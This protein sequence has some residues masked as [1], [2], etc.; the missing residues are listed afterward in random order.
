M[1]EIN[2]TSVW[3]LLILFV[4][5]FTLPNDLAAQ[6]TKGKK[7]G[8]DP[9]PSEEKKNELIEDFAKKSIRHPGLFE[10]YQDSVTGDAYMV[11]RDDQIGKEFIYFSHTIDGIMDVRLIRGGYRG[12]RIVTINKYFERIQIRVHNTGFYYDPDSQLS[13][14]SKA[15]VNDPLVFSE[16]IKAYN[17]ESNQ[18]LI[19]A[20]KLF[21]TEA[22]QQ[23]KPSPPRKPKPAQFSLGSLSKDKSRYLSIRNYP[24]NSDVLVDYVFETQYPKNSGSTA[25]KDARS[26][27]I[28]V[29]HSLIQIPEN[30]YMPRRDDQR[31]GFFSTQITDLTSASATPYRDLINRWHLVK[32]NPDAPLSDPVEPILFWIENTTPLELRAAITE[33][34]LRWN[35]AFQQA[36]FKNAVVVKQQPENA[37]WDAGDIRY[38]VIRWVSS[39]DPAYGGYGPRFVNPRTGQIIGADIM[40]EY[41]WV[42]N[43]L[44]D[45]KVYTSASS[46]QNPHLPESELF[47][48]CNLGGSMQMDRLFGRQVMSA[49][50]M[51]E[52]AENQMLTQSL[53]SLALHE[54]GHTLGLMHNMMASNLH[55]IEDLHNSE[56]TSEVGL[57][58]SVMDY[59]PVNIN[60]YAERQ[61]EYFA[62][63]PGPYDL[64]VIEYGYSPGLDDPVAE[65]V[66]LDNIL[67]RSTEKE[68]WS[69]NDADD[70]RAPGRHIDPR[71]MINDHSNDPIQYA[72]DR[73]EMANTTLAKLKEKYSDPGKSYQELRN[74]Y[75]V[76]T[77]TYA[78]SLGVISRQVGGVYVDRSV[79]GQKGADL[80]LK[81]VPYEN[82][83]RAMDAVA[84]HGFSPTAFSA[85]NDLYNYLLKQR[86]G[87][88]H[89]RNNEDFKIHDRIL[90]H[91]EDLLN[92]LLHKSVLKRITDSELYGNKYDL[93]SFMTDLTNSIYKTDLNKN[94]NA[95][96]QNLQTEYINRLINIIGPKSAYDN[97][98]QSMALYEL[99]RIRKIT[100][101]SS[102]PGLSTLAHRESIIYRIGKALEI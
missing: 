36:G 2:H 19:D 73:I 80:P 90:G 23:V 24:Q 29:Q 78:S 45:Q 82:Q 42:T 88:D 62:T 70:M 74:A 99:R 69:G 100:S 28:K 12:S 43:R 63:V 5:L 71:A 35:I 37:E 40:L 18:Y 4:V 93:S 68:L 17:R 16:K 6:K 95:I 84:K 50:N 26:I 59:A 76:L 7:K 46:H 34:V 41:V 38:N 98:A 72:L 15:N 97:V 11:I 31:M 1:K 3:P 61:G 79:T 27:S 92:H 85:P 67:A 33:G 65:E 30:D 8:G 32:K 54:V 53:Y 56:I 14:A 21:L 48:F 75:V 20:N 102:S 96:R 101:N 47:G 57:S 51:P 52:A 83:K 10:M 66:R 86:R 94:V 87:L 55:S 60:K 22:L 89:H 39:P 25:V 91:Q 49:F 13:N 58:S 44:R 64:W 77:G 9:A 81:P